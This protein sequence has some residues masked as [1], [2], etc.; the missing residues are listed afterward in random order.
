MKFRTE[1]LLS[2]AGQKALHNFDGGA[3]FA[4]RMATTALG[5]F[6]PSDDNDEAEKTVEWFHDNFSPSKGEPGIDGNNIWW[7]GEKGPR[8]LGLRMTFLAM[9]A[10]VSETEE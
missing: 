10:A 9:A 6:D 3:C 2:A 8:N 5:G 1:I 4:I 7:L